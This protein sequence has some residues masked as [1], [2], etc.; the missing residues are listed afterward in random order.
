M[1]RHVRPIHCLH[2]E[3]MVDAS[4]TDLREGCFDWEVDDLLEGYANEDGSSLA[5]RCRIRKLAV[6]ATLY[7]GIETYC[8]ILRR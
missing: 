4:W 3:S 5:L 7:F 2:D 1:L 6:D 8:T